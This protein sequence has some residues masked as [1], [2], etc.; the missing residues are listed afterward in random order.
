MVRYKYT[1]FLTCFLSSS[2]YRF[3]TLFV[4]KT[5]VFVTKAK[6]SH[7]NKSA[8]VY[9]FAC[10]LWYSMLVPLSLFPFRIRLTIGLENNANVYLYEHIYIPYFF[11]ANITNVEANK[12]RS[13]FAIHIAIQKFLLFAI[14]GGIWNPIL[15]QHVQHFCIAWPWQL[16]NISRRTNFI[17]SHI[18]NNTMIA[19]SFINIE[20]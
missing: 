12:N 18:I 13:P 10:V 9:A 4:E 8:K 3:S 2:L 19:L 5:A 6:Y 1:A 20:N 7:S 11:C 17:E 16:F 14:V 15:L